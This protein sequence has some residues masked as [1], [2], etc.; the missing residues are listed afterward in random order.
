MPELWEQLEPPDGVA[1]LQRAYDRR[2]RAYRM[3][4]AGL[5]QA[6][7][8]E[9]MGVSAGR[10][11][12]M[13]AQF[14]RKRHGLSPIEAWLQDWKGL[15]RY[16]K[17]VGPMTTKELLHRAL[18]VAGRAAREKAAAEELAQ[19]RKAEAEKREADWQAAIARADKVRLRQMELEAHWRA[20]GKGTRDLPA[21]YP[22]IDRKKRTKQMAAIEVQ[23][24]QWCGRRHAMTCPRI[25]EIEWDP[26][27]NRMKRVVFWDFGPA[28]NPS[29]E[30]QFRY[31]GVDTDGR[32]EGQSG[33]RSEGNGGNAGDYDRRSSQ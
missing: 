15:F 25:R 1:E 19:L 23:D 28:T 2:A 33:D 8:G 24:C 17:R 20:E 10:A 3:S 9:R 26:A 6:A 16:A 32:S 13:V 30:A 27:T 5:T 14:R 31:W 12:Q 4:E 29:F 11:G 7:I 21:G 22:Q 18:D